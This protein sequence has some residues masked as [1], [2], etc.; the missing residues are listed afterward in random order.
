MEREGDRAGCAVRDSTSISNYF[1]FFGHIAVKLA[2][3]LSPFV[4]M[5]AELNGALFFL[6]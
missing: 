4:M 5:N 1:I 2:V 3:L 6:C